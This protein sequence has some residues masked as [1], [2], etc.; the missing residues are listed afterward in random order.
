MPDSPQQVTNADFVRD[1]VAWALAVM[2]HAYIGVDDF[3]R[4]WNTTLLS[5]RIWPGASRGAPP[6]IPASTV[7]ETARFLAHRFGG[8]AEPLS[9]SMRRVVGGRSA[10]ADGRPPTVP[11]EGAV[12]AVARARAAWE[13]VAPQGA[14]PGV[15]Q[16]DPDIA[17]E[18]ALALT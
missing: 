7:R 12:G 13:E 2:R 17:L 6:S 3:V 14:S 10:L 8:G 15:L 16:S 4:M 11:T 18:R 9:E 1:N 5:E